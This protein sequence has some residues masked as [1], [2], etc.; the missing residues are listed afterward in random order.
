MDFSSSLT[1]LLG[2]YPACNVLS[3]TRPSHSWVKACC[4]RPYELHTDRGRALIDSHDKFYETGRPGT[5]CRVRS[6]DRRCHNQSLHAHIPLGYL[7]CSGSALCYAS[8]SPGGMM[9]SR[10]A[11]RTLPV[12]ILT[13]GSSNHASGI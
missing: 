1:S 7:Y 8:L 5:D 9:V 4:M 6:D 3:L 13:Y 2:L 11:D 12:S 10:E